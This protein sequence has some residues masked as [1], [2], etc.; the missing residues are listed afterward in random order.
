MFDQSESTIDIS[1]IKLPE[2][3]KNSDENQTYRARLKEFEDLPDKLTFQKKFL[4]NMVVKDINGKMV[5]KASKIELS[6]QGMDVVVD[7]GDDILKEVKPV[8]MSCAVREP[9]PKVDYIIQNFDFKKVHELMR[10]R[11]WVWTNIKGVPN[12]QQLKEC[13]HDLL[14]RVV[15]NG[16]VGSSG[17]GFNVEHKNEVLTLRFKDDKTK[18]VIE[19][20]Q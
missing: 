17:G 19:L 18:T 4:R 15:E 3:F 2:Y 8:S 5:G 20:S 12:V 1:E 11:D 6:E 9:H 7:L 13:A 10:K 16:W 14:R